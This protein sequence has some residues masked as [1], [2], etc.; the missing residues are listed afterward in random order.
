MERN[1]AGR[2]DPV[3][4]AGSVL[5]SHRITRLERTYET[6]YSNRPPIPIA[7]ISTKPPLVAPHPGASSTLPGTATPPPPWAAIPAPHHSLRG[8]AFPF[9]QPKPPLVQ[10][11]AISSG[12]VCC[13]G[14]PR[15]IGFSPAMQL[16][17]IPLKG[18]P[19]LR[20]IHTTSQLGVT[21]GLTEGPSFRSSVRILN[22]MGP[23]HS[24]HR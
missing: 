17:E 19:T 20:R 5:Y 11:V 10:P 4:W 9:V 3:P 8:K 13:L 22:K 2:S 23:P 21:S 7:P 1:E 14:E 18:L 15:P 12:P 6:I 24:G 16:I